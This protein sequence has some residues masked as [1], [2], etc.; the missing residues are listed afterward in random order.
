MRAGFPALFRRFP[1]FAVPPDGVH[2]LPV[3]WNRQ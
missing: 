1:D 3:T 2:A